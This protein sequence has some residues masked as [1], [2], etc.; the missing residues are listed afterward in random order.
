MENAPFDPCCILL[1]LATTC[2]N[3]LSPSR[4]ASVGPTLMR[5]SHLV[6]GTLPEVGIKLLGQFTFPLFP[7]LPALCSDFHFAEHCRSSFAFFVHI[8]IYPD[9]LF[10]FPC[11]AEKFIYSS[12][13]VPRVKNY[14][15]SFALL[16]E[17]EFQFLLPLC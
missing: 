16:L 2:H 10:E 15:I 5:D 3:L 9:C 7:G 12:L 1:Q 8:Y 13:S 6:G 17:M 11:F 4:Y 14:F